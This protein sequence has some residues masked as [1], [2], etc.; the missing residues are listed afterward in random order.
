V[1][2]KRGQ[3]GHAR[4]GMGAITQAM[5]KECTSR[6]V[7]LMT[8]APVARVVVRSGR[9]AG[10]E[11]AD[12]TVI[13]GARV[14]AN[15]NPKL[16]FERLVDPQHVD[17]DFRA[18]IAAYRC[19]SGTFRMNVALS[20]LPDFSA[21]PGDTAQPHHSSGIV[22]AP[23]LAYME[24]AYFDART[25]G[26]SQ[27]PIVEIL[28]PSTVDDAWRMTASSTLAFALKAEHWVRPAA[29]Q[30]RLKA[31]SVLESANRL[32]RRLQ[33]TE[34]RECS[35]ICRRQRAHRLADW[36]ERVPY[37][38]RLRGEI[39]RLLQPRRICW[40]PDVHQIAVTA[41]SEGAHQLMFP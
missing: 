36:C 13:E 7:V 4:G 33:F 22:M 31:R 5:A 37:R 14:V 40:R 41:L 6:G 2:G 1:N 32:M 3:W 19:G 35:D 17:A 34:H 9:A 12:G 10:L 25:H 21:L 16:L 26:W 28:I 23:T 27:A 18:R 29:T 11:L 8:N 39:G 24:R 15:V 38:S 20:E 30:D